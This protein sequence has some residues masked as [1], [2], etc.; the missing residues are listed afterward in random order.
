MSC[1]WLRANAITNSTKSTRPSSRQA[2][3]I[4]A[5]VQALRGL[6]N[7]AWSDFAVLARQRDLLAPLRALCDELEVKAGL[8]TEDD[9]QRHPMRNIVTRALGSRTEVAAD[10]ALWPVTFTAADNDLDSLYDSLAATTAKVETF[11]AAQGEIHRAVEALQRAA[12]AVAAGG[13]APPE[14]KR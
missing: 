3:A 10:V 8:L 5:R 7:S 12:L 6:A 2:A 4:V 11:L 9:A 1:R 14:G 13:G